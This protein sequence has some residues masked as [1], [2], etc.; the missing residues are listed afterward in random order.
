MTIGKRLDDLEDSLTRREAVICW[1]RE[2]HEFRVLRWLLP[3]A[4]GPAR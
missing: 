1:L 3:L 4:A 2:V